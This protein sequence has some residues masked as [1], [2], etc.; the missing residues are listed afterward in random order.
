MKKVLNRILV[1]RQVSLVSISPLPI[2]YS[3]VKRDSGA[4]L[5]LNVQVKELFMCQVDCF[6]KKLS[7]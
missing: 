2:L 3:W 5:T 1:N 4:I 7:V 6:S